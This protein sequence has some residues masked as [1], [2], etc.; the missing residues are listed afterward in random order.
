M[1]HASGVAVLNPTGIDV[2]GDIGS[3]ETA[4]IFDSMARSA[5]ETTSCVNLERRP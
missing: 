1:N 2:S 5:A 4:A 3:H